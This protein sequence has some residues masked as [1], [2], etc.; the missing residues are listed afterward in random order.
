MA[1]DST[2]TPVA[3]KAQGMRKNGTLADLD[4]LGQ[5]LTMYRKA[6]A[7]REEAFQTYS[8]ADVLRKASSE[9]QGG[10]SCQSTREGAK[11][12]KGGG[13]RGRHI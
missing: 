6:V 8:R 2:A 7:R 3:A 1:E 12:R 9:R 5:I 4:I 10:G 11:G 13:A